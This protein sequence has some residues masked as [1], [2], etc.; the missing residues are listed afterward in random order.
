MPLDGY[1]PYIINR[2]IS[3]IDPSFGELAN[4]FN[5]KVF[6]EDKVLH[7]KTMI[8][9]LPKVRSVPKIN[10]IK[11]FKDENTEEDRRIKIIAEQLEISQREAANIIESL[12]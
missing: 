2:W 5:T 3:F 6:L 10:Y 4:Y 1:S 8:S 11:K 9:L 12:T 7:Y